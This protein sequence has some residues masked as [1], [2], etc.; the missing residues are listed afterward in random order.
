MDTKTAPVIRKDFI[1]IRPLT[2]H[3]VGSFNLTLPCAVGLPFVPLPAC[4]LAQ[5]R[6]VLVTYYRNLIDFY[7]L[8]PHKY[9]HHLI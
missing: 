1:F 8:Y 7:G 5:V 3:P 9:T 2:A 4:Q 6:P